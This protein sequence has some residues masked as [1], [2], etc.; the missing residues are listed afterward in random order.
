MDNRKLIW[1]ALCL[2]LLTAVFTGCAHREYQADPYAAEFQRPTDELASFDYDRSPVPVK[3]KYQGLRSG[4]A[5][6]KVRFRVR[7]VE[8]IKEK[9]AT[10]YL[11]VPLERNVRRPAVIILPPTGGNY[12]LMLSFGEYFA[13]R[14]FVALVFKRRAR[15]FKP[16]REL[17]Y[18]TVLF[19]QAVIDIRRCIDLLQQQPYVDPERIG[20]MGVSLGAILGQLAAEA[21]PRIKSCVMLLGAS[22]LPQIL[23]NSDYIVVRR[24]R[25]AIRERH[26]V[27]KKDLEQFAR[28]QLGEV[29]PYAY[30]DR[31]DPQS[32]LMIN[33]YFDCIIKYS[34]AKDS[35]ENSGRPEM[36]VVP[37]GHYSSFLMMGYAYKRIQRHLCRTLDHPYI[38]P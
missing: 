33:G 31:I 28:L 25:K 15:F 8:L 7:D 6:Y 12:N 18:N 1:P 10:A 32:L 23:V 13:Q 20:I 19:R 26:D 37:T 36:Y 22:D 38:D 9:V 17:D 21:D 3:W 16:D 11:F 29:D 2:L 4:C 30:A 24:L 27:S 35:W 14:G 5:L 34:V